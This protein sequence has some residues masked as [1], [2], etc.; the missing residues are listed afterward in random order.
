LQGQSKVFQDDTLGSVKA[1]LFR[2]GNLKLDRMVDIKWQPL[3]LK[4]L[5][6]RERAA[7][8][9]AGLNPDAYK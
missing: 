6:K 1:R 7:F 8:I 5:A 4:E 9:A 3:S 2:D